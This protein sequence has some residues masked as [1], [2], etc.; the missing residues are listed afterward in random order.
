MDNAL[1][2]SDLLGQL[3]AYRW[4]IAGVLIAT[5]LLI[6]V[7]GLT[8]GR[9]NPRLFARIM[10]VPVYL[11]VLPGVLMLLVMGY[12]MFFTRQNLMTDLDL[13]LGV[14]PVATMAVSLWLIRREV[15]FQDIPGFDELGGMVVLA[16]L[17]F[18]ALLLI[19]KL[20]VL[21][22]V[23]GGMPAVIGVF[24]LF[25]AGFHWALKKIRG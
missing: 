8:L 9:S 22:G 15:R 2:F 14:L 17:A 25:Y 4:P 19:L 23:F 1:T 11:V 20:R 18:V 21:V 24:L 10:S 16:L 12:M 6:W 13:V 5:P 7:A 3:A